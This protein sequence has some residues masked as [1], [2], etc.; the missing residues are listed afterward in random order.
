MFTCHIPPGIA[1][2]FAVAVF[3][4]REFADD[5]AFRILEDHRDDLERVTE[6]LIEREV[7]SVSEIEEMIGKRPGGMN[8]PVSPVREGEIVASIDDPS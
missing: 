8:G 2:A 4:F 3:C 1:N 6:A 5:R 7:L